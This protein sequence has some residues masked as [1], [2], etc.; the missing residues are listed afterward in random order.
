MNRPEDRKI[1]VEDLIRLKRSE[2]PA[3]EYWAQF[4]AQMHAKQL[5]AIVVKR[6]WW[7][8]ASRVFAGFTRYS[9]P[10][11]AAAAVALA[12]VG[13]RHISSSEATVRVAPLASVS[14]AQAPEA[15]AEP[16]VSTSRNASASGSQAML[17]AEVNRPVVPVVA[18]HASHLTQIPAEVSAQPAP[19]SPF[20]DGVSVSLADFRQVSTAL[21]TPVRDVF[22]TDREFEASVT[23]TPRSPDA[24]PLARLDPTAERR[25][26]LLAPALPAYAS[27][28]NRVLAASLTK[29]RDND[30]MYESMDISGSSDRSMV[31]FRF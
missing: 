16:Q 2:R 13:V 27:S 15:K 4:E 20:A 12:W 17:V 6:P 14:S 29:S 11:G 22:G 9:L 18:E 26:R 1:T 23:P 3:P 8:G 28:G 24:E 19:R 7:D 31:G 5:A 21:P 25:E 10:V 30:R